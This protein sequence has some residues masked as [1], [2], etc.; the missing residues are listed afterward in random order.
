[1][2]NI[3]RILVP[4]DGSEIAVRAVKAAAEI[5]EL[6][7]AEIALLYVSL[8]P[9]DTD[10]TKRA[11]KSWL[12]GLATVSVKKMSRDI[13]KKATDILPDGVPY[14]TYVRVG[15]PEEVIVNFAETEQIDMVIMGGHGL[16]VVTGF[17]LGSVSQ[18]VLEAVQQPLMI[19]K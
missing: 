13:M 9:E 2:R 19:V 8:L 16:G 7:G 18:A 4:V 3:K 17:L 10:D 6:Y 1:M 12:P 14:N 11:A 15:K 5:A